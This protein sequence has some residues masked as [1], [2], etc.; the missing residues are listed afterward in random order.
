VPTITR[1]SP[2]TCGCTVESECEE[3]K[4]PVFL[5]MNTVCNKHQPL[6]S[7]QHR[8]DHSLKSSHVLDLIEEAKAVNLKQVNDRIAEEKSALRRRD[9]LACKQQ[10]IAFNARLDEEWTELVQ[11]AYAFDQHEQIKQEQI[12]YQQQQMQSKKTPT[13]TNIKYKWPTLP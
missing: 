13:T 5:M 12:Q 6:M 8:A 3:G 2:N 11:P 4:D 10:V 9:L 7:T 1:H